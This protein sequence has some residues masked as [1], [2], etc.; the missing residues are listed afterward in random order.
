[1]WACDA[2]PLA[3]LRASL[4]TWFPR[5]NEIIRMIGSQNLLTTRRAWP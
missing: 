4:P 2:R 3:A 5:V 1:M